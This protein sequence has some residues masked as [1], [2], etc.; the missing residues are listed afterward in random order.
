[1]TPTA[2]RPRNICAAEQKPVHWVGAGLSVAAGYPST[3]A[4]L[5]ALREVA[6]RD[7]P[8]G[9]FTAV[10][11]AFVG[12]GGPGELYSTAPSTPAT[13]TPRSGTSPE[14]SA[15]ASPPRCYPRPPSR[16]CT[17]GPPRSTAGPPA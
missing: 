2:A 16:P 9:E 10:V 11:D 4:I 13:L 15:R 3:G 1:M 7:L 6:D 5:T 14:A 12:A 8:D 17:D